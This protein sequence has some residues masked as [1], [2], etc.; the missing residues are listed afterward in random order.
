[1]TTSAPSVPAGPDEAR[2]QAVPAPGTAPPSSRPGARSQWAGRARRLLLGLVALVGVLLLLSMMIGSERT[3]E[4]LDPRSAGPS[5]SKALAEILRDRG[6]EVSVHDTFGSLRSR[7]ADDATVVVTSADMLTVENAERLREHV[8]PARRLVLVTP[9]QETLDALRLGLTTNPVPGTGRLDAGCEDPSGVVAAGDRLHTPQATYRGEGDAITYC[10]PSSAE[11]GDQGVVA[12]VP[13][14]Q[15]RPEVVVLGSE[16]ALSNRYLDDDAHAGVTIRALGPSDRLLWYYPGE[17][18]AF[19]EEGGPEIAPAWL[20]PAFVLGLAAVLVLA[21]VRGRRLGRLVPEPLPVVVRANET[22]HSRA[23]LF[24]AAREPGRAGQV[25][26]TS[27]RRRLTPRLGATTADSPERL[28]ALAA[29]ASGLPTEQVAALLD[30]PPP[31]DDA[32]LCQ[33]ARDL[34]DLEERV[35]HT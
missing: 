35:R 13:A 21:L 17:A 32:A 22:T 25:L 5:G 2:V 12:V 30:G 7:P 20:V 1:M 3:D 4:P 24:R 11:S 27:T 28:H 15:A 16:A 14:T 8:T 26:R 6:V 34:L 18:D 10:F 29:A 33:L 9:T 19:G 23:R 31:A